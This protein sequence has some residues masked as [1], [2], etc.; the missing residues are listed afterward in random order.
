MDVLFRALTRVSKCIACTFRPRLGQGRACRECLS[1]YLFP[2]GSMRGGNAVNHLRHRPYLCQSN[3]HRRSARRPVLSTTL[4]FMF[5]P[6]WVAV[7]A[8]TSGRRPQGEAE[9]KRMRAAVCSCFV[10]LFVI[11]HVAP[12]KVPSRTR[13]GA[14]G[15]PSHK[16]L[17]YSS[18]KVA[19]SVAC[20]PLWGIGSG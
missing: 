10:C 20:S 7:A 5:R 1:A 6:S 11:C 12:T 16:R 15:R 17:C 2:P 4:T 13:R 9:G 8:R 14:P 18:P 3:T 19:L